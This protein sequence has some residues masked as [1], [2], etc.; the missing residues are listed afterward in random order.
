LHSGEKGDI[1][2]WRQNAMKLGQ[3]V[4]K[5]NDAHFSGVEA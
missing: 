3:I 5:I 1:Q 2:K 4:L